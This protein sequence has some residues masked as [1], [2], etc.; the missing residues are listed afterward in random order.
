MR[1]L[2]IHLTDED[3]YLLGLEAERRYGALLV[4]RL[5]EWMVHQEAR[6]AIYNSSSQTENSAWRSELNAVINKEN[7]SQEDNGSRRGGNGHGN[8][9][10]K[11]RQ[12]AGTS[13]CA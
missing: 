5:V 12:P 7:T 10:R 2:I 4:A 11:R 9:R 6:M 1:R 8:V 3:Y 13:N